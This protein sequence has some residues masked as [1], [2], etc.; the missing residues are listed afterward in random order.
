[1]ADDVATDDETGWFILMVPRG[2][3][4]KAGPFS[5]CFSCADY[6]CFCIFGHPVV[7]DIQQVTSLLQ[8]ERQIV[9]HSRSQLNVVNMCF[10][11]IY[12]GCERCCE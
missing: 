9:I 3:A 1:M 6:C 12:P 5:N 8:K 10:T 2:K 11:C 4:E 7:I